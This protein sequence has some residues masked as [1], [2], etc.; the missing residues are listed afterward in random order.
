[1][2]SSKEQIIFYSL[3]DMDMT[4]AHGLPGSFT[5]MR[6][7]VSPYPNTLKSIYNSTES[8][9]TYYYD[10]LLSYVFEMDTSFRQP[11]LH[12]LNMTRMRPIIS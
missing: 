8:S 7:L 2:N 4:P 6:Q 11:M 1:M 12:V 5:L 10:P 9:N 3:A